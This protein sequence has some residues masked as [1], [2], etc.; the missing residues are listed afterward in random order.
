[1][2][3]YDEIPESGLVI[4]DG[5]DAGA[6]ANAMSDVLAGRVVNRPSSFE[7]S[8]ADEAFREVIKKFVRVRRARGL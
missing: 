4:L 5:H 3:E 6:W 2:H 8:S 7:A 1:M